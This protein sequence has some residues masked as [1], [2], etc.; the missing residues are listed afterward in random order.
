M[1]AQIDAMMPRLIGATQA[2]REAM[3]S[4]AVHEALKELGDAAEAAFPTNDPEAA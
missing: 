1:L 4:D 3:F 2:E